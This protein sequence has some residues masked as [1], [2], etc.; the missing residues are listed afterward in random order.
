MPPPLFVPTDYA[1]ALSDSL[2]LEEAVA[3]AFTRTPF[4]DVAALTEAVSLGPNVQPAESFT[5]TEA[6]WAAFTKAIS[7]ALP[8]SET[9]FEEEAR[10]L[11]ESLAATEVISYTTVK[12]VLEA[13][14]L[15]EGVFYYL[16]SQTGINDAAINSTT[17]G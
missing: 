3:I 2:P 5:F 7:E 9:V 15:T 17:L 8:L 12:A 16:Q 14:A 10:V 6:R 11:I 1:Q 13:F 4:T